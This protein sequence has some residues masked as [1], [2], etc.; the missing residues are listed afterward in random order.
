ME[1][2]ITQA[3]TAQ[4]GVELMMGIID[5]I[6]A[7]RPDMVERA[8]EKALG[9]KATVGD[10]VFNAAMGKRVEAVTTFDP[11]SNAVA[12]VKAAYVISQERVAELEAALQEIRTLARTV[13]LGS[14]GLDRVE[15]AGLCA[16]VLDK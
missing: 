16:K 4:A 10:D 13:P 9:V 1:L 14:Y 7:R 8:C 11:L 15:V 2:L 6:N 5:H 12:G 3:K